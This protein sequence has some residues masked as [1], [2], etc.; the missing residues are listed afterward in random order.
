MR[1]IKLLLFVALVLTA[2]SCSKKDEYPRKFIRSEF[3]NGEVKM[4]TKTGK[5]TDRQVIDQFVERV[6]DFALNSSN[7]PVNVYSFDDAS[8]MMNHYN[9]EITLT[10]DTEGIITIISNDYQPINFYLTKKNDYYLISMSDTVVDYNYIENPK[11]TG[12]PEIVERI[13][14]PM[15]LDIVKYLMPIYI[16][17]NDDEI[18]VCVVSYM[19]RSYS[20]DSQLVSQAISAPINNLINND[21]LLFIQ[22]PSYNLIDTMAYKESYIVF[23]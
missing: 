21:Y 10:S 3:L 9:M 5:V 8:F 2:I 20:T 1:R 13:P 23:K 19:E 7:P 4:F 17:K 14:R 15:G 22:N 6:K 12:R 16:K 11:Y 18:L